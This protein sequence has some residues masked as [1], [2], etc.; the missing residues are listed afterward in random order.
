MAWS[1]NPYTRIYY[2]RLFSIMIA[3]GWWNG[4]FFQSVLILAVAK[5]LEG[6]VFEMATINRGAR[7]RNSSGRSSETAKAH[8]G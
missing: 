3:L 4:T 6:T 5:C 7:A 2:F 8:R 1:D